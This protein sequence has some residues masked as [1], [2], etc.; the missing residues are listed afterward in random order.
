M[1]K[2]IFQEE[3]CKGLRPLVNAYRGLLA[4]S[5]TRLN[6]KGH[7]PV[8]L[9]EPDRIHI[10]YAFC[11][12]MCPDYCNHYGRN[13]GRKD[14][15]KVLMKGNG[16]H[17]R[18]RDPRWLPPLSWAIPSTPQ[19][20]VAAYMGKDNAER[21]AGRFAG[22]GEDRGHQHG[23]AAW[24]RRASGRDLV[25]QPR[26]R[27]QNARAFRIWRAQICPQSLSMC[28]AAGPASAAFSRRSRLLPRDART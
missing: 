5:K 8:E 24:P 1:A 14:A 20:E 6:Q 16:G 18:G 12:M 4:L 25:L 17:R 23:L 21:S 27:A 3:L 9:T 26:Y 13:G 19:T 11:A 2:L 28:S 22:R 10:G 7:A 15:G